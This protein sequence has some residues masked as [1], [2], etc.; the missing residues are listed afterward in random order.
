M[1]RNRLE[2][3]SAP[4]RVVPSFVRR[5]ELQRHP[6]RWDEES[7]NRGRMIQR[8]RQ[9][10]VPNLKFLWRVLCKPLVCIGKADRLDSCLLATV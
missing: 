5:R 7:V 6:S 1:G 3:S 10:A 4:R 9:R 8:Q 2:I